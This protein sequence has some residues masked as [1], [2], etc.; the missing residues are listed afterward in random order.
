MIGAVFASNFRVEVNYSGPIIAE[1]FALN[2]FTVTPGGQSPDSINQVNT[3]SI[4]LEFIPDVSI[5]TDVNYF[6]GTTGILAP[7]SIAIV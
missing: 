1:T 6:G 4:E 7:D 5:A 3:T 2:K